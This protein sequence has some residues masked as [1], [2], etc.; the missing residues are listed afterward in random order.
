[1]DCDRYQAGQQLGFPVLDSGVSIQ[2]GEARGPR[3]V[4][5]EERAGVLSYCRGAEYAVCCWTGPAG[6]SADTRIISPITR[7][8][9]IATNSSILRPKVRRSKSS[10]ACKSVELTQEI[11]TVTFVFLP[12]DLRRIPL[13]GAHDRL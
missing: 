6:S 12:R 7:T 1:M 5:R 9:R 3:L 2:E 10:M 13:P 4:R 8:E 11:S